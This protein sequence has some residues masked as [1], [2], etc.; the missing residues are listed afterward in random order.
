M[1]LFY[2]TITG[3][4]SIFN[5]KINTNIYWLLSVYLGSIFFYEDGKD[6]ASYIDFV[7]SENITREYLF[8][9]LLN[10]YTGDYSRLDVFL[11]LIG[12]FFGSWISS[13]IFYSTLLGFIYGYFWSRLLAF[14]KNDSSLSYYSSGLISMIIFVLLNPVFGI[15]Q[16]FYLASIVVLFFVTRF[17]KNKKFYEFIAGTIF[18]TL[19]HSAIFP[20]SLV[21]II[22]YLLRDMLVLSSVIFL[23][24]LI[25][26]EV[27]FDYLISSDY[28]T[29]G[30]QDK[31]TTYTEESF[32]EKVDSM[33]G[34]SGL[35]FFNLR[36][37]LFFYLCYMISISFMIYKFF[38]SNVFADKKVDIVSVL[39]FLSFYNIFKS[40]PMVFRY[41]TLLVVIISY[42]IIRIFNNFRGVR[43]LDFL[44]KISTLFF[45]L[46]QM[47]LVLQFIP[48][49]VF[50]PGFFIPY[51]VQDSLDIY[52]SIFKL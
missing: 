29:S 4:V 16:R 6:F 25:F 34:D 44:F 47:R 2:P 32:A 20:L 42:C 41:E 45:V 51:A 10:I 37:K 30:I 3:L 21:F 28:L 48:Q 35:W 52:T 12:L 5:R 31:L 22:V 40:F 23:F 19:I 26:S 7:T 33:R 8:V 15:N 50:L 17:F 46:V 49:S 1:F 18:A 13:P 39:I 36:T 38:N 11:D 43:L 24:S 14:V 9:K 27:I